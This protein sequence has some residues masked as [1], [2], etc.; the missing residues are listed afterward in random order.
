MIFR[1]K[2]L[3]GESQKLKRAT[4]GHYAGPPFRIHD[5][6]VTAHDISHG[7]RDFAPTAYT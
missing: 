3:K 1:G 5:G 4:A 6:M 7:I 2:K